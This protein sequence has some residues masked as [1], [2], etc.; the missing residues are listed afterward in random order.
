MGLVQVMLILLLV[1]ALT[2]AGFQIL[3]SRAAPEASV[4]QEQALAW[5]DQAVAAFAAANSRLP[6]PA[7]EPNGREDCALGLSKGYLPT[8]TLDT[9]FDHNSSSIIGASGIGRLPSPVLYAVY[10]ASAASPA[11][12]DGIDLSLADSRYAPLHY[13][14]DKDEFEPRPAFDK[15]DYDAVNGLD[16]CAALGQAGALPYSSGRLNIPAASG[17]SMNVAYGVAIAGPTPGRDGRFDDANSGND[18]RLAAPGA[19]ASADYDDRVRVRTFDSLAQAAGCTLLSPMAAAKG[20]AAFYDTVPVATTDQVASSADISDSIAD[21]QENT[22]DSAQDAVDG[23]IQ[24]VV[25]GSIGVALNGAG[26]AAAGIDLGEAIGLLTQNV[27]RCVATLGAE[28]WRVA[29]ST[30]AVV[31]QAIA[32]ASNITA[33]GLSI[34]ALADSGSALAQAKT[35][36]ALAN[37]AINADPND[38]ASVIEQACRAAYG[39]SDYG[40]DCPRSDDTDK[41]AIKGLKQVAAE[42]EAKAQDAE[43]DRD[44]FYNQYMVHWE[45]ENLRYRIAGFDGLSAADKTL[46]ITTL[47]YQLQM[48]RNL[49]DARIRRDELQ[50]ND[51]VYKERQKQLQDMVADGG[52]FRSETATLCT[53]GAYQD[54]LRCASNNKQ[55]AY[56]QTCIRD[57]ILETYD[58]TQKAA[59]G[60]Y[61][62]PALAAAITANQKALDDYRNNELANA[63]HAADSAGATREG[64]SVFHPEVKDDK[65]NIIQASYYTWFEPYRYRYPS[66]SQ[67]PYCTQQMKD[68][69]KCSDLTV[70]FAHWQYGN[71]LPLVRDDGQSGAW[72]SYG[73]AYREYKTRQ[74][75]A[76]EARSAADEAASQYASAVRSYEDLK[77]LALGGGGGDAIEFWI[78]ADAILKGVDDRGA[79][80]P[81]RNGTTQATAKP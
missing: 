17:A 7:A 70:L 40:S 60:P 29:F 11:V 27:V 62:L 65:G 49:M 52:S 32:L 81:D 56:A 21:T 64:Y 74:D 79:V 37:S 9:F 71:Y 31:S 41:N 55:I 26:V 57:G 13:D 28:C 33:L 77:H 78:G 16:F 2:A 76:Q 46:Q 45:T 24:S 54:Q 18:V 6:C 22:R 5:A 48:A 73:D 67:W 43:K 42:L 61:C 25:F 8:G 51:K 36:L 69:K 50:G 30:A 35:A 53:S 3:Q 39:G 12:G 72:M 47:Q 15:G 38:L 4:G 68:D 66:G 19:A 58:A 44:A 23:G 75:S 34:G 1:A 59:D 10:R 63:Q 20:R 14:A 80:G